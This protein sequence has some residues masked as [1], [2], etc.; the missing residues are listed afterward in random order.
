MCTCGRGVPTLEHQL[1]ECS[2]TEEAKLWKPF[3]AHMAKDKEEELNI[4][5]RR[6][7]LPMNF[8]SPRFARSLAQ[9]AVTALRCWNRRGEEADPEPAIPAAADTPATGPAEPE[10][11]REDSRGSRD[12]DEEET[13]YPT[14][15]PF[16]QLD[17]ARQRICCRKCGAQT[18]RGT[19]PDLPD[20]TEIVSGCKKKEQQKAGTE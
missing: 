12:L 4:A 8:R 20:S 10:W 15:I 3:H 1:W 11:A 7:A 17:N 16:V 14:E 18:Y 19:G 5:E 6:C 13:Y 2:I 9:H